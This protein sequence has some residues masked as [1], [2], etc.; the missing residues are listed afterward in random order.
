MALVKSWT[1]VVTIASSRLFITTRAN[2]SSEKSWTYA[3][4]LGFSGTI[5]GDAVRPLPGLSDV[6]TVQ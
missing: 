4:R 6:T 5:E 1:A 3:A 2:G